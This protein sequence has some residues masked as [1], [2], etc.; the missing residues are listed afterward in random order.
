[1]VGAVMEVK[2]VVVDM[3]AM[4]VIELEQSAGAMEVTVVKAVMEAQLVM[5][6][7]PDK[8]DR[9]RLSVHSIQALLAERVHLVLAVRQVQVEIGVQVQPEHQG[10]ELMELPA[11]LVH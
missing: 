5:E 7:R 3:A 4:E 9:L 8:M 10:M 11:A 1:M 2:A 6:A